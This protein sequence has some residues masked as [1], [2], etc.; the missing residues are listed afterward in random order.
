MDLIEANE[1][2]CSVC[3]CQRALLGFDIRQ[4]ERQRRNCSGAT[5]VSASGARILV[6][7]LYAMKHRGARR[8]TSYLCIGG[9]MSC[10]TI[11]EMD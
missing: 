6:T 5:P 1:A 7:L 4:G 3:G 11:V 2:F 9:G 10:A 8:A